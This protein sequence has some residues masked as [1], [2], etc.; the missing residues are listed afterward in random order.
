MDWN[1]I[2]DPDKIIDV[3]KKKLSDLSRWYTVIIAALFLLIALKGMIYSI[4]P[5]EVGV[6]QRFGKFIGL[7]E[8][9]ME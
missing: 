2:P 7:T 5:D 3:G 8:W 6:I 4:G 1:N 9:G